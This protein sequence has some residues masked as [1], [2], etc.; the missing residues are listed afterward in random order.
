MK[1]FMVCMSLLVV[2]CGCGSDSTNSSVEPKNSDTTES[3]VYVIPTFTSVELYQDGTLISDSNLEV[4]KEVSVQIELLDGTPGFDFWINNQYESQSG[5]WENVKSDQR[6]VTYTFTPSSLGSYN[7]WIEFTD[8]NSSTEKYSTSVAYTVIDNSNNTDQQPSPRFDFTALL[9]GNG[10]DRVQGTYIDNDGYIFIAGQTGSKNL[11]VGEGVYQAVKPTDRDSD[12]N[13]ANDYESSEGFVGK[14]S[15]DGKQIIWLTYF[16]GSRRDALYAV[17]T[18]SAGNVYVVG[19]T[20]S[21]DFPTAGTFP[22][23]Y[24]KG[25]PAT[26]GLLD[27]F[28]AKLDPEG[29][30]LIWSNLIGGTEG[31]EETPRGSILIDEQRERVYVSGVT[32]ARDFPTTSDVY[33][34]EYNANQ[35]AFVFALRMDGKSI[36]ASTYVGGSGGDY[37]ASGIV[38]N[39]VDGSIYISGVTNSS[40]LIPDSVPGYQKTFRST[41]KNPDASIWS[42]GDGFII[43]LDADLKAV[44]SGTYIGGTGFDEVSHNQGISINSKGQPVVAIMTNSNDLFGSSSV[45]GVDTTSN[46]AY[47]G[48]LAIFSPDLTSLIAGT[49]IGGSG[50]DELHGVAVGPE[51]R[52][53]V[54]GGT[55]SDDFPIMIPIDEVSNNV[56]TNR[57]SGQYATV[58]VFSED[59]GSQV[60]S[61]LLGGPVYSE[62]SQRGRS[63]AVGQNKAVIGGTTGSSAFPNDG[64][65][66]GT[67]GSGLRSA[68]IGVMSID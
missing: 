51:N 41:N 68:F 56:S 67:F 58:S 28:V 54:T 2:L 22:N 13:N 8:A 55:T 48:A 26:N 16:G 62:E 31:A 46:G 29:K 5:S 50:D 18:D 45:S 35:E 57:E 52:V 63:F 59:L 66:T 9:G 27:V 37:A 25:T 21:S 32:S 47:D 24:L 60:Y 4:Y 1:K 44:I 43:R 7:L 20:G 49:Y 11:A 6:V 42:N 17:R 39:P 3:D 36:V 65:F 53:F 15:Q 33:Q 34:E 14:L 10:M 40:D 19:S 61:G 38:Q 23:N 64:N 12:P 30:N